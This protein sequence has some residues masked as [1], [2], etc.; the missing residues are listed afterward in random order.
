[1]VKTNKKGLF[2]IGQTGSDKVGK[3]DDTVDGEE[4]EAQYDKLG[5]VDDCCCG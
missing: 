4:A 5:F 2:F 1:M 3:E